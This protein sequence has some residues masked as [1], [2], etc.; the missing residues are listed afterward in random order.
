MNLRLSA[1]QQ[2]LVDT[3]ASLYRDLSPTSVVRAAES[4]SGID[5]K[6]WTALVE[7]G[8]ITMGVPEEHGG[9]GAEMLDLALVAEQHGRHLAPAPLIEAQVATRLL[10]SLVDDGAALDLS[11][12]LSSGRVVTLTV[13]PSSGS[14]ATLVPG[15][16][17]ADVALVLSGQRLLIF[18]LEGH[19]TKVDN[20]GGLPL[21]DITVPADAT[22][23]ASGP[24][25]QTAFSVA[26]FEWLSLMGAALVGIGER[27]LEIGVDYARERKAFGQPIGAF[28]EVAHRLADVA[29]AIDGARLLARE[30]AWAASADPDRFHQLAAMGFAFA[31]ETARAA[32]YR[33]LHVHGGYGSM[34]EYD[35]QLYFRRAWAWAAQY[36]PPESA[37]DL[38]A[39]QRY[40]LGAER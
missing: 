21:A 38:V 36:G 5:N 18:D 7:T 14:L 35:I 22:E 37:Y 24:R 8:A 25:A 33:S 15:G 29:T 12:L 4:G 2:L 17:V 23:I 28:Q 34:A 19:R 6:L 26:R 30:A 39:D 32:G 40:G 10:A 31:A 20:T 11:D 13:R 1:D 16:W 27:A 3:F 9:G